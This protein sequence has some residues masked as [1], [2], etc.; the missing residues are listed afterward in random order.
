MNIQNFMRYYF[1]RKVITFIY[2]ILF[3][4]FLLFGHFFSKITSFFFYLLMKMD[5]AKIPR[6]EWMD[7]DQ[8]TFFQFNSNGTFF[9]LERGIIPRLYLLNSLITNK[10]IENLKLDKKINI[11]DLCSGDSY[12][13]QKFFYDVSE[14]IVS[15]DLDPSAL[16][17]GKN[18]IKK[19]Q[20]MNKKHYFF[21]FDVEKIKIKDFLKNK[22]L[23]IVFDV[24]LFN[25][26]IEHFKK[27][28]LDFI[29]L[30]LKEVMG[31]RSFVSIYTLIES[32]NEKKYLPEYH[33]IFFSNKKHL[34]NLVSKFFKFT[35]SHYSISNNRCNI[36][37]IAS[38][39]EIKI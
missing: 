16:S 30:S 10:E 19:N 8:D 17:R 24:I 32:E 7:H 15:L 2:P 23:D 34:E 1:V 25:A 11:L 33:K 20:Y 26:A 9:H 28:Q 4:L 29:F 22:K 3:P 31:K 37:C 27:E 13:S 6:T 39:H 38:D 14:T 21:P 35:K 12:I 18:R 5:W 36:Y